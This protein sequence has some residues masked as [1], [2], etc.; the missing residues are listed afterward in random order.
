MYLAGRDLTEFLKNQLSTV[1][2]LDTETARKIKEHRDMLKVAIDYNQVVSQ[3]PNAPQTPENEPYEM[4][5]GTTIQVSRKH[6]FSCPEILFQP[7]L[8]GLQIEGIHK[9]CIESINSHPE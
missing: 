1:T 3:H 4:P 6:R 2:S 9:Q 7:S 8:A 5:D